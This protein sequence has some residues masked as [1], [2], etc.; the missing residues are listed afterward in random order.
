MI[1]IN[2]SV[3]T[4]QVD[5]SNFG[6]FDLTRVKIKAVVLAIVI[7]YV[8]DFTLFSFWD[9]ELENKNNEL[10]TLIAESNKLKSQVAQFSALEKQIKDLKEQEENLKK[11]LTAVK[12]AIS[13]KRSPV[14][15]LLYIAKNIP[16]TLWLTELSLKGTTLLVKGEALSYMNVG[17]FVNSLRSSVF[18]RDASI[19]NTASIIKEDGKTRLETF[20]IQFELSRFE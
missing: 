15:I 3:S 5:I 1:K 2:L 10:S 11:K 20:E 14:Q 16:Q 13:Q 9:S 8:P 19:K 4:K 17:E 6:G 7:L 18:I 12:E